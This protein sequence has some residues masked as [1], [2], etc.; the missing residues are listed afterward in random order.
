[1]P[2][3]NMLYKRRNE[4][5]RKVKRTASIVL[6]LAF[7]IVMLSSCKALSVVNSDPVVLKVGS[8]TY[9]FSDYAE[10]FNSELYT[11]VY[12]GGE[13]QHNPEY[14]SQ[15]STERLKVFQDYVYD[16]LIEQG[17][18]DYV[19]AKEKLAEK[20]DD[21]DNKAIDELVEEAVVSASSAKES[22][23]SESDTTIEEMKTVTKEKEQEPT[24]EE[25]AELDTTTE[26]T[27]ETAIAEKMSV[28]ADD[29]DDTTDSDEVTASDDT[30]DTDV[31]GSDDTEKKS[32]TREE[33]EKALAE[34]NG[35]DTFEEYVQSVKDKA[36]FNLYFGYY[37]KIKARQLFEEQY[38]DDHD[39]KTFEE[40]VKELREDKQLQYLR[41]TKV[42]NY[43][44]GDYTASE[45]DAKTYYDDEMKKYEDMEASEYYSYL[46]GALKEEDSDIW[47]I[48]DGYYYVKHILLEKVEA[49]GSDDVTDSDEV[50]V[51]A[52]KQAAVEAKIAEINEMEDV[53]KKL[54]AFDALMEEYGTDPGMQSEPAKTTGYLMGE[55]NSMVE[56]FSKASEELYKAGVIGAI[57]DAVKSTHGFHYIQLVSK[58][59]PKKVTFEEVKDKCVEE[60][61]EQSVGTLFTEKLMGFKKEV[62][63]T[64]Y[65]VRI[66]STGSDYASMYF[67]SAD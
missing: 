20:L 4:M 52:E 58:V 16:K 25:I 59:E 42:K 19:I 61:T 43:L 41:D 62:R 36:E 24:E 49:T 14:A 15:S 18:K 22:D 44:V 63:V 21:D 56:E 66:R 54:R 7:V 48:K 9:K 45:D 35:F 31:T 60:A 3:V 67:S 47:Y 5:L 2:S 6:T 65:R 12:S 40:Y 32:L 29:E 50:K 10:I 30:E 17:I 8:I 26:T 55:G 64:E 51:D 1:M 34:E 11:Y 33:A 28:T 53:E 13:A 46:D 23:V 27:I 57:S 38:A 37:K 39:G